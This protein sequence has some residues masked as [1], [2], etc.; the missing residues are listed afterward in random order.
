MAVGRAC[1][2]Y[3]PVI[4]FSETKYNLREYVI[5]AIKSIVY[6]NVVETFDF[7]NIFD[8]AS[9]FYTDVIIAS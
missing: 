2:R 7:R 1:A 3:C 4:E 8:R 9:R 5:I 6:V